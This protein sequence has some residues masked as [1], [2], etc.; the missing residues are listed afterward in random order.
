MQQKDIQAQKDYQRLVK[1]LGPKPK[2]ARDLWRAFLLGGTFSILAQVLFDLFS[3]VEPSEGEAVAA[4]QAGMILV[5]AI[6]TGFGVY[7][8]IAEWGGAG[9]AVP[10]TGF[11]NTIVA[12]AMDFHREGFILGLGSKM[13]IIAG[14]ILVYGVV[15]GFFAG[16][17]KVLVLGL[18]H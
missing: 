6:L 10:V 3:K 16:L 9:A 15:A 5:G 13:F 14:P 11:A 1:E 4:A 2:I 17:I 12:A 8:N 7:D 18:L